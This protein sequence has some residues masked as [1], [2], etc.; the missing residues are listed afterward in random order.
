MDELGLRVLRERLLRQG[1]A[2]GH[3]RRIIFELRGHRA[4]LVSELEAD[5]LA[6]A[7]A[8]SQAATRMGSVAAVEASVLAR[9]ELMSRAR[10]VPYLAFTLLPLLSYLVLFALLIAAL[11]EGFQLAEHGFGIAPGSSRLL[12]W[13]RTALIGAALWM[14]P[15]AAA[16][17]AC[18][19][20][21][22]RR[23]PLLWPLV[24]TVLIGLVG[25]VTQASLE[26]PT[27]APRGVLSLGLGFRTDSLHAELR[28]G[29]TLLLVL[30]P[31]LYWEFSRRAA[32]R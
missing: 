1:V 18:V 16:G 9:P 22:R 13:L 20:A 24:G 15:V 8:E 28:A 32:A 27:S 26:W 5:G 31:Y 23:A 29:V 11:V 17:L 2:P 21:A 30:A 10:R 14:A 6:R 12:A 4:D 19:L 7:D 25:A 3:V